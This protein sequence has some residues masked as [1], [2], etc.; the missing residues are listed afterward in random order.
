MRA[1]LPCNALLPCTK[2]TRTRKPSRSSSPRPTGSVGLE[3][4]IIISPATRPGWATSRP[5]GSA[6]TQRSRSTPASR[7][8]R[9]SI[10]TCSRSGTEAPQGYAFVTSRRRR[11]KLPINLGVFVDEVYR[12][13]DTVV[14]EV[15]QSMGIAA[16]VLDKSVEI[17]GNLDGPLRVDRVNV[18]VPFGD[19]LLL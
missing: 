17:V 18:G 9:A 6:S 3:S 1:N 4:C 15:H 7:R 11:I 19:W 14:V 13:D 2:W 12:T 16:L 10:R 5:P 8:A